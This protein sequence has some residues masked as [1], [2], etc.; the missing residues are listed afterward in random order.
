MN[1]ILTRGRGLGFTLIELL[2][3][4]AIIALLAALLLPAFS[5][6]KARARRVAC[7][8]NLRQVGYGFHLFANDHQGKFPMQV[9]GREGGSADFA[10]TVA[11]SEGE[12]H[13]AFRHFQSLSNELGT[14]QILICPADSRQATNRFTRLQNDNVSY[15]VNVSAQNGKTT[16]ILAGDRNLTN[17]YAASDSSFQLHANNYLRWTRE[18]HRY[19]G[20]ILYGDAHVEE[21]NRGPVMV[22]VQDLQPAQLHLP[23][24]SAR[25]G[26][27]RPGSATPVPLQ[28]AT[29][30]EGSG[31]AP[32]NSPS[33]ETAPSSPLSESAAGAVRNSST[34]IKGNGVTV[35]QPPA[36]S[37]APATNRNRAPPSPAAT[38]RPLA[39][40]PVADASMS[41][42]DL[43][44]VQFLQDVVKWSYLILLLLL[45]IYLSFRLWLWLSERRERR[46][47]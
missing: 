2:V 25:A 47:G 41:I 37:A 22:S 8:N 19:R 15:F 43:Q 26:S 4:L 29:D 39:A 3:V 9:P 5:Q 10:Q 17:D 45:L 28:T 44:L 31:S 20:N 11:R 30:L 38:A 12:F 46:R 34:A 13:S 35:L 1:R 32:T 21:L 7:V 40:P 27:S 33:H 24:V 6:A 42:F 23:A 36:P 16:S 14:P 18:L